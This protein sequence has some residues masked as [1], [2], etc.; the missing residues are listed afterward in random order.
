MGSRAYYELMHAKPA[1]VLQSGAFFPNGA[2][3]IV[4]ASNIGSGPNGTN[5]FSVVRNSA[6]NYTVT[7]VDTFKNGL[8]PILLQLYLAGGTPSG[9][10]LDIVS[11]TTN[12]F[13]V[14]YSVAGTPTDLAAAATTKIGFMAVANNFG[15][16]S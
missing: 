3:A 8:D 16:A 7:F 12:S 10:A 13:T 11:Q 14:V 6:G 15:G 1:R 9:A 2:S 5:V 4:N